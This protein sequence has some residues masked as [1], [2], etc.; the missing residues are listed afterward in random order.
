[1]A[2]NPIDSRS[3][4]S[5]GVVAIANLQRVFYTHSY[6]PPDLLF[7]SLLIGARE[8][9]EATSRGKSD[10]REGNEATAGVAAGVFMAGTLLCDDH[11]VPARV[12]NP[13]ENM[14]TLDF[15][16]GTLHV[17]TQIYAEDG[18]AT[19]YFAVSVG[20]KILEKTFLVRNAVTERVLAHIS[21]DEI[22]KPHFFTQ[23]LPFICK[24]TQFDPGLISSTGESALLDQSIE[25][26][27]AV[28]VNGHLRDVCVRKEKG[29]G[30]GHALD[31][32]TGRSL[33]VLPMDSFNNLAQ[34]IATLP[35]FLAAP[36]KPE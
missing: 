33:C 1:M 5:S 15:V 14:Y 34:L 20:G 35:V 10:P 7:E 12:S 28:Q 18:S 13:S 36:A 22:R 2:K 21:E 17:T 16:E 27:L 25:L 8:S 3:I 6:G 29:E 4:D 32:K 23:D 24:N 11:F 19:S 9:Y 26:R 31:P 30:Q